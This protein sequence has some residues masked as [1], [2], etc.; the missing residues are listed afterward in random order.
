[1]V[2][3]LA[4]W[5]AAGQNPANFP[6]YL[7]RSLE[8]A[9]GYAD[10]MGLQE[11]ASLLAWGLA[12][13]AACLAFLAHAAWAHRD[14]AFG[15]CAAGFAGLVWLVAWKEGFIRADSHVMG[16]FCFTIIAAVAL[17]GIFFPEQR[18]HWFELAPLICLGGVHAT[19]E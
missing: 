18:L 9:S 13:A 4:A 6:P 17:P 15:L 12:A 11:S 10:A 5:L 3:V 19:E 8:V 14:R 2:A 16:F 1:A 7:Q